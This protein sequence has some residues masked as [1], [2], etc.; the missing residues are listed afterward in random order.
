[1]R[2]KIHLVINYFLKQ[3]ITYIFKNSP[4]SNST[5]C[6]NRFVKHNLQYKCII[7]QSLIY[8]AECGNISCKFDTMLR[9]QQNCIKA[10]AKIE[11]NIELC[12]F[13]IITFKFA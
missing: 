11:N 7:I 1:M 12:P 9:Y 8:K 10:S 5:N 13:S 4:K 3:N 6:P 2:F